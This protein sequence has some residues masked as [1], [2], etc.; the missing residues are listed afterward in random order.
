M[1]RFANFSSSSIHKLTTS[2][3]KGD[4]FGKPALTYIKEKIYESELGRPLQKEAKAKPTSWGNLCEP[5]VFNLLPLEYQ[6]VSNERLQ[7]PTIERWNGMPDSLRDDVVGDIKC[8]FTLL[9]FV[10]QVK[11]HEAGLEAFKKECPEYYWQLISNAILSNRSRIESI[12]F[13]PYLDEL[14]A[15]R[16]LADTNPDLGWMKYASDEELPY[17]NR[18]GKFKNLNIFEYD[19]PTEDVVFLESRVKKAV[20]L[21]PWK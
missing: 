8:P 19:V 9:S 7:H 1:K 17:L 6:L 2:N 21:L 14:T 13:V 5:Y 16:V 10:D 18:G 3:P 15:I 4:D 11:A 20:K 12:V